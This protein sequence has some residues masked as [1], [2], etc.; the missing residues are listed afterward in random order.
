MTAPRN[1]PDEI[2]EPRPFDIRDERH[3]YATTMDVSWQFDYATSLER[4]GNLY[5]KAKS[6]QWNA[7]DT[8]KESAT[9]VLR[10]SRAP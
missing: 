4:L 9:Q 6:S 8:L 10:A 2:A 5:D 1:E 7:D 3:T